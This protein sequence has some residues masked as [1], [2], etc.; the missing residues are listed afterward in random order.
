MKK[1]NFGK[2]GLGLFIFLLIFLLA[3]GWK[4]VHMVIYEQLEIHAKSNAKWKEV[5][6]VKIVGNRE[7]G[8]EIVNDFAKQTFNDGDMKI[9]EKLID[10]EATFEKITTD[11]WKTYRNKE[12]GFE[13]KVPQDWTCQI[14][15]FQ[16][17]EKKSHSSNMSQFCSRKTDKYKGGMQ[18]L[19]VHK[20]AND[21]D[22]KKTIRVL[23]IG[24]EK[25]YKFTPH[26]GIGVGFINDDHEID[27]FHGS[28][29]W[30][31]VVERKSS[32]DFDQRVD[33]VIE[34]FI[35]LNKHE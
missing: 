31:L 29:H 23:G 4:F 24:G 8:N 13:I 11:N 18:A 15:D 10:G 7:K 28:D 1:F 27:L 21:S 6:I 3:G 32:E 35:F 17:A 19:I 30:V 5:E 26:Q 2:I 25:V 12:M 9:I 22:Y 20:V 16:S 14:R 34:S 33:G